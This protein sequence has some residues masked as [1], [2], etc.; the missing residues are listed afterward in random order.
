MSSARFEG[1]KDVGGDSVAAVE[2]RETP[3]KFNNRVKDMGSFFLKQVL[4]PPKMAAFRRK[5]IFSPNSLIS[6]NNPDASTIN[7][8]P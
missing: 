1:V 3:T 7:N 6:N 5:K 8:V 4:T 2:P